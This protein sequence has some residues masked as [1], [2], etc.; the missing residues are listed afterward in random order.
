M[1]FPHKY[2][3]LAAHRGV[4]LTLCIDGPET[5]RRQAGLDNLLFFFV[6]YHLA[7]HMGVRPYAVY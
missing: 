4:D 3:R 2:K 1:C 7:V 5:F 6:N